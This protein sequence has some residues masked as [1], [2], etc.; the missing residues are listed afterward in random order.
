VGSRL[1]RFVTRPFW[2]QTVALA[3]HWNHLIPSI[4]TVIRLQFGAWWVIRSGALDKILLGGSFETSDL[5]FVGKFLVPGM[6]VLDIGAHHG[7]YTLL[8]AKRVGR[9]GRVIAFEPSPRERTRLIEHVRLNFFSNIVVE[10]FALGPE[11]SEA[12]LYQVAG[13]EDYCNSLRPPVNKQ[14]EKNLVVQVTSLDEY[15]SER[16]IASIDFVK[17]DTEGAELGILKG[18][19]KLLETKPRPV[20]LCEVA[21]VRTA[22]WG[23]LA[24]E[25][26]TLMRDRGYEWFGTNGGGGLV[27]L[28]ED[29]DLRN[30]NL[31]AIPS[32]KV[33]DTLSRVNRLPEV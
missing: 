12:R 10:S 13:A 6:T 23:Y 21:Q 24:G 5:Q 29:V 2:E 9:S 17:I 30:A 4:P 7:L 8:A 25:I 26:L 16:G 32:E 15:L 18:A 20:V 27:R 22:A 3:Y 19:T 28:E 1:W 33:S 31:V 14:I 11:R